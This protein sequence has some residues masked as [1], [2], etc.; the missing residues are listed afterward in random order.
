VSGLAGPAMG[1]PVYDTMRLWPMKGCPRSVP[2]RSAAATKTELAWAAAMTRMLAIA[3]RFF[4][5]PGMGTQL[6][7]MQTI[8]AP[9][10]AQSR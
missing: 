8:S 3:S 5:C 6:V 7:G 1:Q 9:C 2:T 4:A 10:S